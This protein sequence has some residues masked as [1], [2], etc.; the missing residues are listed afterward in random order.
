MHIQSKFNGGKQVNRS[1][2]GSWEGRCAG[3]ALRVNEGPDWGPICWEK[4]TNSTSSDTFRTVSANK[5][6]ILA[7]DNKRK[8]TEEVKLQCKRQRSVHDSQQGRLD[9]SRYDNKG[10]NAV[11]VPEDLSTANLHEI[12]IRYC[13]VQV[14]VTETSAKQI[15]IK[16]LGQSSGECE[17]EWLEERRKRITSSNVGQIAKRRPTTK[18]TAKVKQLLYT[19]FHG[20]R[21]TDWGLLQEDVSRVV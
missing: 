14:K 19:K 6:K 15:Y 1:Q 21:A 3:A 2:N 12:M 8:A 7:Q 9:Y 4:I 10:P 18:V 16:T 20:N 13:E 5:K 11:E 17:L